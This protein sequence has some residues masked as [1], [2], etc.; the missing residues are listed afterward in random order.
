MTVHIRIDDLAQPIDSTILEE[1]ADIY[2]GIGI[3]LDMQFGSFLSEELQIHGNIQITT[4]SS[5]FGA[6]DQKL[7]ESA[8]RQLWITPPGAT[9]AAAD[10]VVANTISML[11]NP[12]VWGYAAGVSSSDP[13]RS[14][15]LVKAPPNNWPQNIVFSKAYDSSLE[16]DNARDLYYYTDLIVHEIGHT[17]GLNH[18]NNPLDYMYNLPPGQQKKDL[19]ME[20]I[21]NEAPRNDLAKWKDWVKTELKTRKRHFSETDAKTARDTVG[22]F[23]KI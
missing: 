11:S 22:K 2:A 3:T 17:F 16:A 14:P 15:I 4:L 5:I 1:V 12:D 10:T 9:N 18:N 6:E 20:G 23:V 21:L 13:L 7:A 8:V 19:I